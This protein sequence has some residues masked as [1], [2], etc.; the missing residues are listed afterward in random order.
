[1]RKGDANFVEFVNKTL[2]E[3]EQN[4]EAKAIFEKWFGPNTPY[5][6]KR[7]FTITGAKP[8]SGPIWSLSPGRGSQG[9][10]PVLSLFVAFFPVE[11]FCVLSYHFDWSIITSGTYHD[12]LVS[13]VIVTLKL[14][15]ISIA[16]SLSP[17]W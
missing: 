13:G 3:M 15:V 6:L 10:Q 14:S 7:T 9:C 17:A 1:M 8:T 16:L 2:L 12:W 11:V 4:G 5:S